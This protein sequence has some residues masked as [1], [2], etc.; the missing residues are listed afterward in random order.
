MSDAAQQAMRETVGELHRYLSGELAP[1]MV[2]DCLESLSRHPADFAAAA[3]T[4]WIEG[5]HR[6]LGQG[7]PVSDLVYHAMKKLHLL[8]EMDLVGA[9]PL[10]RFLEAL[11]PLLV[12]LCPEDER[13]DLK[14]RLSRLGESE[15][16]TVS[17]ADLQYL[18][19]DGGAG[20]GAAK[21]Q[22]GGS[23]GDMPKEIRKLSLLIER[24]AKLKAPAAPGGS[25]GE[26]PAAPATA[27]E[28]LARF[29]SIA[30]TEARSGGELDG[31]L[32]Q[33]RG[34]GGA[35]PMNQMFRA[36]GASLP[37]WILPAAPGSAGLALGAGA[38]VAAM[39]K[40]VA[41]APDAEEGARRFGELVYAAI[42]QFNEG[43]LAQA[44]AMLDTASRLLAD[45]R[46]DEERA[47]LLLLK[48]QDAVQ[49]ATLRKFS[50]SPEKHGLLRHIL[51]FFPAYRAEGMLDRLCREEKRESRKLLLVLLEC[52]G[53]PCR[54]QLLE[55]LA[56][57]DRGDVPDPH[58][59]FRR[60]FVFLLRR[61]PR[62]EPEA[63]EEEITLLRA[64]IADG[65][66]LLSAREA[67]SA[68]GPIRHPLAEK[69]LVDRLKEL[70][71]GLASGVVPAGEEAWDIL[72]RLCAALAG[73]GTKTSIRTVAAH[74]FGRHPAFGQA[75]ARIEHLSKIDLAADPEQL[76]LLLGTLRNL[77]PARVLGFV[78]KRPTAGI[79]ALL[80]AISGT[81][82]P[83]VRAICQ[84]IVHRFEGGEL[85]VEASKILARLEPRVRPQ[86][87]AAKTMTGDLELFA[88]P[89][90]LQS[91][92]D[93][94]ATGELAL[95]DARQARRAS[96]AFTGG[97]IA[98]CE[99]GK[100]RA[101]VAVY[102]VLE[103]PFPG[104]FVFRGEAD[105]G[106]APAASEDL[107]EI[108]PILLEGVRRHDEFRAARAIAPDG[109][110]YEP[111][112]KA[113]VNDEEESDKGLSQAVWEQASSGVSPETC[114]GA[115]TADA[116]SV[117]TLYAS[118]LEQ[119]A[120]RP[121]AAA[122]R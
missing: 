20:S 121:I 103:E 38:P 98:S 82:T 106:P 70:E 12:R 60:N 10:M 52:L 53:T 83:D 43:R 35:I 8:S 67:I 51:E 90:L 63:S 45:K 36:L 97:R 120:L 17:T 112:G 48:A 23:A 50:E 26:E 28:V 81:P 55:R 31:Y 110:R 37:G 54:G 41:L 15:S 56:A 6:A 96:F 89:N 71:T 99:A 57:C 115:V 108:L 111:T 114:E 16:A 64:T 24:L 117:R 77:L 4:S 58:G 101:E 100:L 113:P 18:H 33:I 47:K 75:I 44:A 21:E 105:G 91:L 42:E 40:M 27:D 74:A 30:A 118:W 19:R 5:Q 65:E 69:A 34:Q 66:P 14:L 78:V 109:S 39:E 116:Y 84:E 68:L 88:V 61:I 73:R 94:Q 119:E 46:V 59:W 93:N 7:V 2:V 85:G 1:M 104:T 22:G 32:E 107:F 102:Q 86:R 87:P 79:M 62:A 9:K 72:D 29:L 25:G 11:T 49:E 92:A 3:I 122:A 80:H 76:G 13:I 95:F